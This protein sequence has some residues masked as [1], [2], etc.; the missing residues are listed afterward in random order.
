MPDLNHQHIIVTASGLA[1]PP[2][3]AEA[4]V[5]W[6]AKLV[7]KVG[8]RILLGPYATRCETL[9]NE[10]VT[11]IVCIETSHSSCH[12]WDVDCVPFGKMDL[13]SCK[14]FDVQVVLDHFAEFD[15]DHIH[16][17]VLDRNHT[18]E[19]L[20]IAHDVPAPCLAGAV[21]A[22]ADGPGSAAETGARDPSARP[23]L[24]SQRAYSGTRQ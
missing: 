12:F 24:G 18:R 22:L 2:R 16:Y 10:G 15:P 9:G 6:L 8:M 4:V 20:I 17:I 11:G 5:V 3:T 7:D 21:Q 1:S 14:D 23:S 19:T 13:Y